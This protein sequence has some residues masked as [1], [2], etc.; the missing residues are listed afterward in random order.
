MLKK[1]TT[2]T[3]AEQKNT[4][5]SEAQI[6]VHWPEEAYFAPTSEFVAQAYLTDK[7]I[8]ERCAEANFPECFKEYAA[9]LDWYEPWNQILD[10]SDPPFW[11]WF[12][13][14]RINACY[15]CL[16][17][18]LAKDKNKAALH[19]VAEPEN[20]LVQHITYQELFVRVNEFRSSGS[21]SI[22]SSTIVS[23]P[24]I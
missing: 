9:L 1:N 19:F 7:G 4:D 23:N 10:T 16:D 8:F 17:R 11:Q 21:S 12:V 18:H 6:A 15:N 24:T 13:G 14:G 22:A 5:V 3:L 20:E 2:N